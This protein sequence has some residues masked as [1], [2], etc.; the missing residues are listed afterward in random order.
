MCLPMAS[1]LRGAGI[2]LCFVV[3]AERD[4]DLGGVVGVV[5]IFDLGRGGS[6]RDQDSAAG[7]CGD[8][9]GH[10]VGD[11]R[12]GRDRAGGPGDRRADLRPAIG[13]G[14]REVLGDDESGDHLVAAA[15]P[16][17]ATVIV[18]E[19]VEPSGA[20]AAPVIET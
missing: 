14:G 11:V 15:G 4:G 20:L 5:G 8:F 3:L 18:S 7:M 13:V 2:W 9:E 16:A 10:G 6:H 1:G 17:F 12:V 19:N